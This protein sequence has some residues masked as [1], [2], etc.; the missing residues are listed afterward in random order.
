MFFRQ[1]RDSTGLILRL[2]KEGFMGCVRVNGKLLATWSDNR[3][4]MTWHSMESAN[5]SRRPH[6]ILCWCPDPSAAR[7]AAKGCP[8]SFDRFTLAR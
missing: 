5:R 8:A 1:P 3:D 2:G 6:E 4:S 7:S